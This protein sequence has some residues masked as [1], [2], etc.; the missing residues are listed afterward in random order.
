[1]A[2]EEVVKI[3]RVET[4]GS[5][6]TV[7]GLKDEIKKLRDALLNCEQGS[8]Q[9]NRIIEQITQNQNDLSTAMNAGKQKAEAL[10]GSYNYLVQT[11]AELKTQWRA[12]TD[13]VARGEIGNQIADIN[14]KLKEL[15]AGIGNYQRNVGNYAGGFAEAMK[16][17]QQS[18]EITRA[19]LESLSK[20]ASGLAGGYAA[21]QGVTALLGVEN[22]KLEQTFIKLQ[23]AI[24]IAQGVG[25]LKD[26]VEGI[27]VAK[28]AFGSA[29][30]AV[31]SFIGGLTAMKAAMVT[32]GIGA[33]VVGLGLLIQYLVESGDEAETAKS[34]IDK[35]NESFA[36][37]ANRLAVM[38]SQANAKIW[39]NYVAAVKKAGNNPDEL[40]QA[41]ETLDKDLK[42]QELTD[43]ENNVKN[44]QENLNTLKSEKRQQDKLKVGDIEDVE[45]MTEEDYDKL[46][47]N[48]NEVE[49]Q[50]EAA[51]ANVAQIKGK[52]AQEKADAVIRDAEEAEE[53][54][55]NEKADKQRKAQA[56][57][58]KKKADDEE[59]KREAKRAQRE[60]ELQRKADEEEAKRKLM[61]GHSDSMSQIGNE[62]SFRQQEIENRYDAM[63]EAS[64][65]SEQIQLEINKLNELR[66]LR[67][68]MHNEEIAQIDAT[69]QSQILSDEE[70][71]KLETE[72]ANMIRQN[73]IDEQKYINQ[74]AALQKQKTK[75]QEKI[76]KA[77]RTATLNIAKQTFGALG[78]M[79]KEDSVTHKALAIASTTIDT[80]QSATAAY[81][82]Y[83]G[84]NQPLAIAAAAAAVASG[85]ANVKKIIS[86]DAEKG[87][88][89]SGGSTGSVTPTFNAE[90]AMPIEYTR[91]LLTSTETDELNQP[92]RVYVVESDITETQNKVKVTESNATF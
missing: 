18:T 22:E 44:L 32:T 30:T 27:G 55:K 23:A 26:L 46:V 69:L 21:V 68:E 28:V 17:Q 37:S 84:I 8:E 52:Q 59:A 48:I 5:E 66:T 7:K 41:K 76:E 6:R 56:A 1:M 67:I 65:P 11:M 74:T 47:K 39:N 38:N 72:K 31:R 58:A 24:A 36:T 88:T 35:L 70:R 49:A 42:K 34:K 43:A 64:T 12:T 90:Q 57:A 40:K 61:Q 19:K 77:K 15:D 81:K 50:L 82:A 33:L 4:Q 54:E 75:E 85:L 73:A 16:E 63:G 78:D 2:Q 91:N 20:I 92:Q 80:Y 71:K 60:A 79:V 29:L 45:E 53:K 51:K 14:N 62:E 87:E 25:G 83:A 86:I 9:Y 10:E 89:G 13:E 3:L